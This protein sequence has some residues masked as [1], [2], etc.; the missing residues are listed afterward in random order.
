MAECLAGVVYVNALA[1]TLK[2]SANPV[3]AARLAEQLDFTCPEVFLG[4]G[5][6]NVFGGGQVS[7]LYVVPPIVV[8]MAKHPMVLNYDLSAIKRV[9]CGAAPLSAEIEKQ[10]LARIP[11]GHL[12]QGT[13][14][15]F[16]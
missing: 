13:Y 6:L 4:A 1:P 16:Y 15:L 9:L 3:S 8:F 12:F 14:T 11:V 10:F 7:S 5:T 2:V